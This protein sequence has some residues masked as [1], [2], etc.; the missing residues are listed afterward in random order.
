MI[1]E[2]NQV[3]FQESN[4]FEIS[5]IHLNDLFHFKHFFFFNFTSGSEIS[6]YYDPMVSKLIAYG[7]TRD[8]AID[9]LRKAL[10]CSTVL[11]VRNNK[12]FLQWI[13]SHP[14]FRSGRFNTHFIQQN[15]SPE[16]IAQLDKACDEVPI[17]AL[18]FDWRDRNKNNNNN[19][20]SPHLKSIP[21]G[22]RNVP[23]TRPNTSIFYSEVEPD[24]DFNIQYTYKLVRQQHLFQISLSRIHSK[25]QHQ[26]QQQQLAAPSGPL[27]VELLLS[28]ESGSQN[29]TLNCVI[30]GVF[31]SF[32]IA[33]TS[34]P[35]STSPLKF[36][37][38]SQEHGTHTIIK[39]PR[40]PEPKSDGG[41]D[42]G[43]S[44]YVSKMPG[45]VVELLVPN[46]SNVKKGQ[47]LLTTYSMKI[48]SQVNAHSDGIVKFFVEANQLFEDGQR[49]LTVE[50][51]NKK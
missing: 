46:G 25:Q 3:K 9:R 44:T 43:E 16:I 36:Y 37:V 51:A 6:I 29:S 49:L 35:Q 50:V 27:T 10:A 12:T 18:L 30:N 32:Q 17:A 20:S 38:H 28:D 34:G 39:R 2:L 21:S 8:I 5:F 24:L 15:F 41:D 4:H 33:S 1:L 47:A 11:G 45:K 7:P 13:L 40:L 48:Q 23:L 26:A 31:H 14:Q 19:H 22:F 42:L